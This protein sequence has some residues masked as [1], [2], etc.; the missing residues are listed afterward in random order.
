MTNL[1]R[2]CYEVVVCE[3]YLLDHSLP[4]GRFDVLEY[5]IS[6]LVSGVYQAIS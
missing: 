5:T 3:N 2:L 6:S 1:P 4:S